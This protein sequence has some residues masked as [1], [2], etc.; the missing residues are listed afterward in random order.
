MQPSARTLAIA[1]GLTLAAGGC[2][3]APSRTACTVAAGTPMVE[4]QMFFGRNIPGRPALTDGE[5]ADFVA[6]VVTPHL[7]GGFTAF[8][9]DGQWMDPATHRIAGEK[10]KVVIVALPDTDAAASAIA[11]VRDAYRAEFHQQ[12][13]GMTVHPTCGA[14]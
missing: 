8:D 14:F 5:W 9:A 10:T 11:V 6:R 12:P 4:Y 1:F 13:V 2:A 3:H 7:P